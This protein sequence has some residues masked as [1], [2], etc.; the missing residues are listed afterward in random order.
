[1]L[2]KIRHYNPETYRRM[3]QLA[4]DFEARGEL[5]D[6]VHNTFGLSDKQFNQVL[7]NTRL[8]AGILR[9]TCRAG[10]LRFDL[11][12]A[13]YLLTGK[14]EQHKVDCDNP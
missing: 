2:E 4:A 11:D 5:Y 7:N 14:A 12:P 6:Y 1:M 3:M 13:E 9:D 8:A 10:K